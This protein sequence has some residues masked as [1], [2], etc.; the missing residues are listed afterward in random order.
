MAEAST[1]KR[2]QTAVL[3]MDDQHDIVSNV[4]ASYPGLLDRA[5][6]SPVDPEAST[7]RAPMRKM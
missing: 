1:I 4:E 5:G 6:D 2:A 7:S 3:I